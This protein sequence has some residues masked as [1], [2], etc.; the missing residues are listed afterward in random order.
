ME[1]EYGRGGWSCLRT[2]R[3]ALEPDDGLLV[4]VK[5]QLNCLLLISLSLTRHATDSCV[6]SLREEQHIVLC[7]CGRAVGRQTKR[8]L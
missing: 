7:A 4:V 5:L 8:R 3:G 2:C 1:K 6:H